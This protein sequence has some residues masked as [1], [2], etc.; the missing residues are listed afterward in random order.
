MSESHARAKPLDRKR[1]IT[2]LLLSGVVVAL[3]LLSARFLARGKQIELLIILLGYLSLLLVC[4][5]LL[6]GPLN[7]L[8]QRRNPVNID[9]RRD[10]G[11]WAGITGCLHVLLVLRGSLGNGQALLYFLSQSCCGYTPLLTVFGLSN[12]AGLFATLLL[13]LLLALSNTFSLR[14]LKGKRWK[15]LQR[16]AYPLALLALAHT[17]GFQ[18]LNLRGPLIIGLIAGLSVIVLVCQGLGMALTL[19]RRT[20][21][22]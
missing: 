22:P 2:H 13:I 16:L 4:V 10:I 9:L 19:A 17:F 6:I 8:R 18:Y 5:T 7:L 3:Y 14:I 12:D 1:W 15:W 21:G 20:R 11:I